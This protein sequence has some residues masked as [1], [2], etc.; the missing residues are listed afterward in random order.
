MT[1][2]TGARPLATNSGR[3]CVGA[4]CSKRAG[5]KCGRQMQGL[6]YATMRDHVG[7]RSF[8]PIQ[9]YLSSKLGCELESHAFGTI[10]LYR[11]ALENMF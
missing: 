9:F 4:E 6:H 7:G 11:Q 2:A 3:R 8:A 10:D 5:A 1:V